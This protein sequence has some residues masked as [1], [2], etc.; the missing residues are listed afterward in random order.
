MPNSLFAKCLTFRR[1][2]L[3][4]LLTLAW[5]QP[6]VWPQTWKAGASKVNITPSESLWMAG[7][8]SRDHP[9]EGKLTELWAKALWLEDSHGSAAV[10]IALDL[11][12]L[13]REMSE[14]LCRRLEAA[15]GLQRDQVVGYPR[16]W[17]VLDE[18]GGGRRD[19]A[20]DRIALLAGCGDRYQCE[21][22]DDTDREVE[23]A[24]NRI[25][26]SPI[27]YLPR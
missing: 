10:L 15:Y 18:R 26:R 8:A 23:L 1:Y 14:S 17:I 9:A 24:H 25:P 21:N 2:C 13:D 11:I 20:G 5:Y 16:R 22:D 12:G 7:Y 19:R 4:L 6:A 3:L 27:P